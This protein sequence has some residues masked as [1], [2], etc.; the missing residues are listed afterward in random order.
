MQI[1]KDVLG[2]GCREVNIFLVFSDVISVENVKATKRC[3]L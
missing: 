2:F 1:S 3:F